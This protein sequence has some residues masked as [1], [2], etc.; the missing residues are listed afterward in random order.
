MNRCMSTSRLQTIIPSLPRG[1]AACLCILLWMGS[2]LAHAGPEADVNVDHDNDLE[3]APTEDAMA[4]ATGLGRDTDVAPMDFCALAPVPDEQGYQIQR[5]IML[6]VAEDPSLQNGPEV[7]RVADGDRTKEEARSILREVEAYGHAR[8]VL[9][10]VFPMKRHY[11]I[12]AKAL[13]SKDMDDKQ[14][15]GLEHARGMLAQDRLATYSVGCADWLVVPFMSRGKAEWSKVKRE[16]SVMDGRGGQRKVEYLAWNLTVRFDLRMEI[17]RRDGESFVHHATIEGHNSGLRSTTNRSAMGMASRSWE[18]LQSSVSVGLPANCPLPSSASSALGL[19]ACGGVSIRFPV[20]GPSVMG[21]GQS[22]G[23]YC[24]ELDDDVARGE[25]SMRDV[26]KCVIRKEVENATLEIQLE[27]KKVCGWRLYSELVPMTG[28]NRGVTMGK[29]EGAR[30]GDYY[31][32]RKSGSSS[33]AECIEGEEVGFVR[34][35]KLGPGG[36]EGR[37][38]PSVV[39]IRAGNPPLGTHMTEYPMHGARLGVVPTLGY[40]GLRGGL[41]SQLVG[42]G[43]VTLSY[44][45]SRYIRLFDEIWSVGS[46]G[47]ARGVGKEWFLTYD[48]GLELNEYLFKRLSIFTSVR[49]GGTSAF[50]KVPYVTAEGDSEVQIGGGVFSIGGR[51]GPEIVLRP[52]WHLRFVIEGRGGLSRA[53]LKNDE[54]APGRQPLDG[55][56]LLM[57]SGGISIAHTF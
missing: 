26:A 33:N 11:L 19:S 29:H 10:T 57:L 55:G 25:A 15:I 38:D 16:K 54:D 52:D 4:E 2:R 6:D 1:W 51:V 12:L 48:V 21:S 47:Y 34:I 39:E 53:T 20:D 45:L 18:D 8:E 9:F 44:D 40:L 14:P 22:S 17:Y 41:R 56:R 5:V 37:A 24:R 49:L 35:T 7:E 42:G 50:K 36:Q 3:E 27:A 32:A 31:V 23:A 46:I 13:A 30:R 28:G 43:S